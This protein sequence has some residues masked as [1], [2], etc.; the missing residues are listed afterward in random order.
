MLIVGSGPAGLTSALAL[1]RMGI[2]SVVITR[3]AG[4]AHTP[5][6]HI[7]N[8]RT[9]EILADLGVIDDVEE[10]AVP[11]AEAPFSLF[12]LTLSGP[13]AARVPAWG[14]GLE[15]QRRYRAASRHLPLNVPQN[16]LEPILADA[17]LQT[18]LV[19]LRYQN[20][21]LRL[22]QNG[23][24]VD[25]SVLERTSGQEYIVRAEYVIG[26]DGANS[27]VLEQIGLSVSGELDLLRTVYAWV[28]VD[29]AQYFSYRPAWCMWPIDFEFCSF[30]MVAPWNEW[31]CGWV[32]PAG[33]VPT[34]AEV[35]EKVRSSIGDPTVE[36]KVKN[37]STWSVNHAA[38]P[39]YS[40]GRV[41]C[42]GDAV[43]RH[44]PTNGLGS[45]TSI[46]DAYNLAWKLQ[47][48]LTGVAGAALLETY[49][50][51]RAP[52]GRRAVDRAYQSVTE[53]FSLGTAIGLKP[54]MTSEQKQQV[55][56]G[57]DADSPEGKQARAAV[58]E[59]RKLM[60]FNFNAHG[61]EL[62]YRYD[63]P[64]ATDT[65]SHDVEP[66]DPGTVDDL[67]YVPSTAPGEHL[68]HAW[69]E[70]NRRRV[71]T[72]DLVGG[73]QFTLIT[74]R[75]GAGWLPALD[76][77]QALY[78][79]PV[80]ARFIGASHG[81]RDPLGEWAQRCAIEED[82]CLLVR[83]DGHIAWRAMSGPDPD[84][85]V[86]AVGRALAIGKSAARRLGLARSQPADP[87]AEGATSGAV[88]E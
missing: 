24:G 11:L 29:L 85:L 86:A 46:A 41:F 26:A 80:V 12:A 66:L 37:V 18:G 56:A 5:R 8:Q 42:M 71:S 13:E 2:P 31:V 43:H 27:R 58:A 87:A 7:T 76:R 73:G 30:T 74:G 25:V 63:D 35:I 16:V 82:G 70:R 22:T 4:L 50:D 34:D 75:G 52:V 65:T 48:V 54:E 81:Y 28:E 55:V 68:P 19:D 39:R 64:N 62:G 21:F 9:L 57:I 77:V 10:R 51:E 79:L 17:A 1:A 3:Y 69:V 88:M 83:P 6:A 61:V 44:P 20:E 40:A 47:L 38:A 23:D 72:V 60:D 78:G 14:A 59:F 67:I 53:V 45:N 49:S 84:A 33:R 36:V 32:D 15:D